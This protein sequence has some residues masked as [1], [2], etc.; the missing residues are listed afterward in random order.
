MTKET[1]QTL[2][3]AIFAVAGLACIVWGGVEVFSAWQTR[4]W[5]VVPG[6]VTR[7]SVRTDRSSKDASYL[8]EYRYEVDGKE[9]TG[10][11]VAY[12]AGNSGTSEKI[13]E[14][15]RRFPIRTKVTVFHDPSNPAS[16]VL[17]PRVGMLGV[18]FLGFGVLVLLFIAY[19]SAYSRARSRAK[20]HATVD[21]EQVKQATTSEEIRRLRI[22]CPRCG[23]L[24]ARET[25]DFDKAVARC[26]PCG[27]VFSFA[28]ILHLKKY[29]AKYQAKTEKRRVRKVPMPSGFQVDHTG[30]RL[31][32]RQSWRSKSSWGWLVGCFAWAAAWYAF[33]PV[34]K[35][36][37]EPPAIQFVLPP[38]L[39][40]IGWTYYTI[41][42]F[43]NYTLI[44]VGDRSM[45]IRQ[46]PLPWKLRRMLATQHVAQFYSTSFPHQPAGEG[47]VDPR[48]LTYLL[49]AK[50]RNGRSVR[51]LEWLENVD[52]ALFI[53][54]QIENFTGIDDE[55]VG[56]SDEIPR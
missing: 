55:K 28:R 24:I 7:S 46:G 3:L 15:H 19:F 32:I 6:R 12:G 41:A 29:Q 42:R 2:F 36:W 1:Q 16:A 37:F 27:S 39:G 21:R 30:G 52:Q 44:T 17:E 18:F 9:Y 45:S 56:T 4:N 20:P 10:S 31:M 35:S 11:R 49:Y 43:V 48:L 25:V 54:Q 34:E 13:R 38:L 51:L 14:F 33:L 5:P 47:A 22:R 23:K 50:L 53:E 8:I 26:R 40:T